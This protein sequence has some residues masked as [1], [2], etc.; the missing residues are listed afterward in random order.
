L[1]QQLYHCNIPDDYR[2]TTTPPHRPASLSIFPSVM[3]RSPQESI[4][5][6]PLLS[7]PPSLLFVL[8]R[9]MKQSSRPACFFLWSRFFRLGSVFF[10]VPVFLLEPVPETQ[11]LPHH[12][13]F[14]SELAFYVLPLVFRRGPFRT[15]FVRAWRHTAF[16]E[17]FS[18]VCVLY[19]GRGIPLTQDITS[20]KKTSFCSQAPTPPLVR[21]RLQWPTSAPSPT[22][23][24]QSSARALRPPFWKFAG[25]GD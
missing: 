20:F 22:P 5:R 23:T 3:R 4:R 7:I 2:R 17:V 16:T 19:R 14:R 18:S 8:Y 21:I 6:P 25:A 11:F 13:L 24:L 10:L 15:F 9:S 1:T 12:P